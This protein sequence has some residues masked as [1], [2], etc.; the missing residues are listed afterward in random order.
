[1][2]LFMGKS[3]KQ[4]QMIGQLDKEFKACARRYGLPYG[5]FPSVPHYQRMLSEIK[6]ISMFKKLDKS[7]VHEMDK[8]LTHDIPL[9][10]Q[11]VCSIDPLL[12]YLVMMIVDLAGHEHSSRSNTRSGTLT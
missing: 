8:V 10:L 6:D 11:R 7:M 3:D 1:M 12:V 2:P 9:L 5:D 4:M